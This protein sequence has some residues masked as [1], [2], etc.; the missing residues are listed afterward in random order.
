MKNEEWGLNKGL[1]LLLVISPMLGRWWRLRHGG[2]MRV[3]AYH[4]GLFVEGGW[5]S[6][7]QARTG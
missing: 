4:D 6:N 3:L 1:L 7:T 5:L 2:P